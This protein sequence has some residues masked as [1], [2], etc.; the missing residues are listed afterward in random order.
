V[1]PDVDQALAA[2]KRALASLQRALTRSRYILRVLA[3][4]ERID[5]TRRLTGDRTGVTDWRREPAAAAG[6]PGAAALSDALARLSWLAR[7]ESYG[8][9]DRAEMASIAQRLL[10]VRDAGAGAAAQVLIRASRSRDAGAIAASID[11]AALGID[12][13]LETQAGAGTAAPAAVPSRVRSALADR[14]RAPARP[15]GG[16]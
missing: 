11:E 13:V 7:K 8:D 2:E 9:A 5:D 15:G 14:L 4:R 16:R 3:T 12:A 10:T 1:R 6:D